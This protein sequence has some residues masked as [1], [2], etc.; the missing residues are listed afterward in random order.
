MYGSCRAGVC[1]AIFVF[2]SAGWPVAALAQPTVTLTVG[3]NSAAEAGQA[4]GSFTVTRNSDTAASLSVWVTVTGSAGI[5]VDYS[6]PGVDFR[7]GPNVY[8]ITIESGQLSKTVTLTPIRDNLIEGTE[9]FIVTMQAPGDVGND[10]II[11]NPSSGQINIT[12]DVAAVTLTIDDNSAAEASQA[13][14]SFTVTRNGS[15]NTAASLSVWV[16]VTGSGGISVD[17]SAPGVDFRAVPNFY[18]ITIGGGQLSKTVTLTPIR[19]NLIEGTENFIVT[20]QAPGDVEHGYTIGNPS[21]GQIDITDD[22]AAVTLTID[23]NSAAEA[24][25]ATGSFTVT[26]NGSGNTAAS[27]SV[28]V[29]VTGSAGISVDYSVPGVGFRAGPNFYSITIEGGQLSKTVTLT[30]IRDN[31]IE[32]TETFI[33]TMQAPGDVDS[34]YTIGNPSSGQ[35]NITDDVAAVTLTIDDNSAAEAAQATGSFTVTRNGSGNTAAS[36]SVWVTVTGSGGIGVDYSVPGVDFRAGPNLHS[37]TIGGGQLSKTV[38]LT[39]V[40]DETIEGDETFIVN[41]VSPGDAGHDYTIGMPA[42]GQITILDFIQLIFK[43]SFEGP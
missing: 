40:F 26:R 9:T 22:V 17:Y 1:V 19:D 21:S 15:G 23:D 10:Y 24:A 7:A 42:E 3:D 35:I 8:S 41:L 38:T 25:Q 32:G 29:T 18:S 33:V 27:L 13:T 4:T 5:S 12:D 20:M 39:P 28:W 34:D 16:T 37:I 31:L 11:G 43:D 2:L 6:V 30:P 36:L 14:G